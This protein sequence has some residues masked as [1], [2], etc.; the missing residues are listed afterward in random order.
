MEETRHYRLAVTDDDQTRFI[1]W[2]EAL[3]S[4]TRSNMTIIDEALAAKVDGYTYNPLDGT[5]QLTSQGN[6]VGDPILV[7]GTEWGSF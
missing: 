4:T 5:I 2:R 3:N 6:P 1:D 7:E